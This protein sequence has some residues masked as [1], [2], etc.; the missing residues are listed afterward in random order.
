MKAPNADETRRHGEAMDLTHQRADGSGDARARTLLIADLRCDFAFT[1]YMIC[2]AIVV[3]KIVLLVME[4]LR[5]EN[6]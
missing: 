5:F 6:H 4:H 3:M 2:Y 1:S